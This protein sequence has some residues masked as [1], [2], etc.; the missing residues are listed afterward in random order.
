MLRG[1]SWNNKPQNT[2]AANRNRNEPAKRNNNNGFRLASTPTIA[3]AV[4]F[5]D[6]TVRVEA[7]TGRHDEC[8][9]PLH[10]AFQLGMKEGFTNKKVGRCC[11]TKPNMLNWHYDGS[12]LICAMLGFVVL[13]ANL[14]LC[15]NASVAIWVCY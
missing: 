4:A 7:S 8:S 10:F 5:K 2:R 12:C 9:T 13:N 1:G 15:E 6:A 11:G 14:Q 3:G